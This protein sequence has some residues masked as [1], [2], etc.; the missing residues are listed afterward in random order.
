[1]TD[2]V[3]NLILEQIQLLGRGQEELR[4]EFV[5]G[6]ESIR[7]EVADLKSRIT[8]FETTLGYVMAQMGHL[9]S[10]LAIQSGRLDRI[11]S[12][13]DRIDSRLDR[14]ERHLNLTPA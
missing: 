9:Q 8:G 2:N 3:S 12:R 6:Q 5:R 14:I 4:N 1:M 7:A 10:Q 13:F 11:D